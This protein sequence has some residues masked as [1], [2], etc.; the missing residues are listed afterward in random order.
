MSRAVVLG[1]IV[2]AAIS[3]GAVLAFN[4]LSGGGEAQTP[5]V[6]TPL[7]GIGHDTARLTFTEAQ[8]RAMIEEAI[9]SECSDS[10]P[11]ATQQH[12]DLARNTMAFISDDHWVLDVMTSDYLKAN[13]FEDGT[14]SGTLMDYIIGKCLV[15]PR[16]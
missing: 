1:V 13:I 4:V 14:V 9:R 7:S 8:A 11:Q 2:V 12:L 16:P 3:I 5:P 6:T 15:D 10:Y